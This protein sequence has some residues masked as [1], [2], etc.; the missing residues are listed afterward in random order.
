MRRRIQIAIGLGSC[1]FRMGGLGAQANSD[2]LS[3]VYTQKMEKYLDKEKKAGE[4]FYFTKEGIEVYAP[5][6]DTL[7]KKLE[8]VL[9]WREIEYY[10]HIFEKHEYPEI[11]SL[12]PDSVPAKELSVPLRVHP[13]SPKPLL[14]CKIAL[15]P[16]HIAGDL[17]TAK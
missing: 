9:H 17:E 6:A 1:L 8:F 2:S 10:K 12:L 3:A 13:D 4:F 15:D 16:G 7:P 5:S 14:H 11:L